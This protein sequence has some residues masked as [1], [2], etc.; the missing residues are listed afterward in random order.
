[1]LVRKCAKGHEVQLYKNTTP[2]AKRTQ[3]YQDGTVVTLSYPSPA[4]DYFV[5]VDGE[6]VK[7]SD[8]FAT[9]ENTFVS[10]CG[11]KHS[12]GNGRIDF[13]KHKL[14]DRKVVKR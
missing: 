2:S 13:V 12:D 3:T 14:V 5:I 8:S 11:K 9:A 7:R 1:M 10:E 4:K 6:I